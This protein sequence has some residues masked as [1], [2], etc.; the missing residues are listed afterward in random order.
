[1]TSD[2]PNRVLIVDDH[3]IVCRG[4]RQLLNDQSDLAPAGIASTPIEALDLAAE[5]EPDLVLVDITLTDEGDA[6]GLDLIKRLHNLESPPFILA[7]SM[8][9]ESLYAQ[10]VLTAG[11]QG[12]IM[13]RVPD[14]EI[15]KAIRR[16]LEGR[17]YVS[18]AIRERLLT[19]PNEE[20]SG[21]PVDQLSNRELEVFLLIGQGF[22][23]RHIAEKLHL[24]VKTVETHRR[25]LKQ[26]LGVEGSAELTRYAIAWRV[27]RST[28]ENGAKQPVDA[29]PGERP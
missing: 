21:S 1:M 17:I 6:E 16:V 24:S 9:D 5:H 12:Y 2:S 23:P 4:L 14:E 18:D 8:H 13:K 22:A 26:K 3:A 29:E 19:A 28:E 27:E 15:L 11:A 25:H 10:R 20:E 7:V